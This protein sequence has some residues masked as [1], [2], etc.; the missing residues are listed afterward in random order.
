VRER[1]HEALEGLAVTRP[2]GRLEQPHAV[3]RS[4]EHLA[5]AASWSGAP[6]IAT[7]AHGHADPKE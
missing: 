1:A 2:D 6:D 5:V 3:Q 7:A 4:I